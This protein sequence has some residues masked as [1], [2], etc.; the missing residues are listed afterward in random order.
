MG[1]GGAVMVCS[2]GWNLTVSGWRCARGHWGVNRLLCPRELLPPSAQ[3]P[4][5]EHGGDKNAPLLSAW[6]AG[7]GD[8]ENGQ[9]TSLPGLVPGQWG[10]FTL[11]PRPGSLCGAAGSGERPLW[12]WGLLGGAR[13][14]GQ[15]CGQ[16]DGEVG[17]SAIFSAFSHS[18]FP[19][20]GCEGLGRGAAGRGHFSIVT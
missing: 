17:Q 11:G 9:V 7:G 19:L 14:G 15:G 6:G 5:R 8:F 12:G 2:H 4:R 3:A 16:G 13:G 1:R 18:P 10:A 20:P